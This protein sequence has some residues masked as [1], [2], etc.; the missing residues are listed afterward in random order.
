MAARPARLLE[1][2]TFPAPALVPA[3]DG[4]ALDGLR[5]PRIAPDA[6]EGFRDTVEE[7]LRWSRSHRRES[8]FLAYAQ[9][10]GALH[11]EEA[12][13]GGAHEITWQWRHPEATVALSFHTHPTR[14]AAC[15]PSGLDVLGALVRGDHLHYILTMDG[16]LTGWRF[17]RPATEARAVH[18]ALRD[19]S[20]AH[21]LKRSFVAYV[22]RALGETALSLMECAYETRI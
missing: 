3:A 21:R 16:K 15:A 8:G 5:R 10:G 17:R 20:D 14:N 12:S 7:L 4:H 6:I 13:Y 2:A 22:E 19:L 1:A 11:A 9:S 18:E